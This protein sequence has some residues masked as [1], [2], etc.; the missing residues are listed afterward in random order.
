MFGGLGGLGDIAKLMSLAKDLQGNIKNM[1]EE[2]KDLEF[3]GSSGNGAIKAVVSGK[4]DVKKIFIRQEALDLNDREMLEDLV[5]TAVNAAL[6]EAKEA[7]KAK[8]GSMTGGLGVNL[9]GLF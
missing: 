8:I 4:M 1:Q 3:T 9:P 2:M 6:N 5:T 7:L